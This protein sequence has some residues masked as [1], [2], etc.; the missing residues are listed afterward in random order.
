MKNIIIQYSGLSIFD[1]ALYNIN[2]INVFYS[3][4]N[5]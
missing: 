3:N 2:K 1:P 4:Y 5:N